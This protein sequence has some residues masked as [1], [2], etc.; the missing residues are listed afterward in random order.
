MIY[1]CWGEAELRFS[2]YCCL[3]KVVGRGG[4]RRPPNNPLKAR[5]VD[6]RNSPSPCAAIVKDWNILACQRIFSW[7]FTFFFYFF[8]L[9]IFSFYGWEKIFLICLLMYIQS[10][11]SHPLQT[12]QGHGPNASTFK[13]NLVA[14]SDAGA[15]NI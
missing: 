2:K 3:K 7:I 6:A 15:E 12:K 9:I 8:F 4:G 11:Q 14:S 5:P 10:F 1:T 13:T